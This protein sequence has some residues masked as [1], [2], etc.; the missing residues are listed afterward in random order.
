[1]IAMCRDGGLGVAR[2]LLLNQDSYRRWLAYAHLTNKAETGMMSPF[3]EWT[4]E[5]LVWCKNLIV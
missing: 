4:I 2:P 3:H 1:M 5:H